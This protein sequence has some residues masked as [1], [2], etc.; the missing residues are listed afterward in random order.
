MRLLTGPAPGPA[1]PVLEMALAHALVRQASRGEIGPTLRIY[2]P[3]SATA[4][5]GRSDVRREGFAN[6]AATCAERGFEPVV[7]APGGRAV[8][9]TDQALVLDVISPQDK[10]NDGIRRRFADFGAV[11]ADVLCDFG[12]DARVGEVPGEYCPGSYSINARG[13]SKLI[14]TAQRVV[15][16]AWLLSA[17]VVVDDAP[18]LR[19][20]L[21]ELHAL[22]DLPF[23]T[24]SVG[25]LREEEPDL[26][27]EK[28]SFAITDAMTQGWTIERAEIDVDL[29]AE[30]RTFAPD[31]RIGRPA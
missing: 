6:A 7:R 22:L 30:A 21:Q 16:G 24:A 18:R 8:A 27:L 15:A 9:Y 25:S 1:D 31:H 14:G 19:P 28:L 10:P 12:V 20:L 23:D 11:L 5:F 26:D 4:A 29:V 17:V 13:V 2:R 3:G